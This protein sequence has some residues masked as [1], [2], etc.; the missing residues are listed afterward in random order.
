MS[1]VLK[2][3]QAGATASWVT[4][5]EP[6]SQCGYPFTQQLLLEHFQRLGASLVAQLVKNPP[7][8]LETLV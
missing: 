3:E 8:V 1:S 7:A 2:V 4:E 5:D 6:H